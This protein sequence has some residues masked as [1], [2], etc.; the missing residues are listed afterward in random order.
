PQMT[1][2][3]IKARLKQTGDIIPQMLTGYYVDKLGSGRLNVYRA[4]MNIANVDLSITSNIIVE[5]H[6]GDGDGIPNIGETISIKVEVQ[7]GFGAA[8]AVGVVA[9]ILPQI[10]GVTVSQNTLNYGTIESGNS[11][12]PINAALVIVD[13]SV[14]TL[15]I[16]FTI[17]ITANQ[18]TDFAFAKTFPF[19]INLSMSKPNWPLELNGKAVTAPKVAD[20]DGTG[21]RFVTV[22]DGI[23]HVVDALKNYNEGFPL[24][25]ELQTQ[26]NIAIGHLNGAANTQQIVVITNSG[27]VMMI[28]HL[29]QIV[30]SRNIGFVVRTSPM[31][32][33]LVGNGQN[34]IIFGTQNQRVFILNGHDLSDWGPSP[35][36]I[37]GGIVSQMALGDLNNNG[38]KNI[39]FNTANPST[40]IHALDPSTGENLPGFPI[41]HL[42][43][44]GPSLADL[45]GDGYLEIVIS[46]NNSVNCPVRIYKFDGS[47]VG[48]TTVPSRLNTEIALV[49][50]FENGSVKLVFG[51]VS[52]NLYVLNSDLSNVNGFPKAL[53][54]P[55]TVS[56]VFATLGSESTKSS[57]LADNA[58]SL[59]IIKAS[60][61]YASGY[62]F[63]LECGTLNDAAWIG[64]LNNDNASVFLVSAAA[65]QCIDTKI[66]IRGSFWSSYRANIGN[67]ACFSDIRTPEVDD[68]EPLLTN[69]LLQNYPNPFNPITTI[70]FSI[71]RDG[72]VQIFVYNIKGQLVNT[73]LNEPKKAGQH[74]VRW[75]GIDHQNKAVASG[76]YFYKIQTENF[77]DVK[78]MILVK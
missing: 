1:P 34:Q 26:T 78:K 6:D 71:K 69:S 61:Q 39:V 59:H 44:I 62:P 2:L 65:V 5:E 30:A 28:N 75:N 14:N 15:T 77:T 54:S 25:L 11:V 8:D 57:V 38:V 40:A 52:G 18:G 60:G 33:D 37:N 35:I 10:N 64:A 55:F 63:N 31:I 53:G 16:P 51:D 7:N 17:Q 58:G 73:L 21:N 68:I 32:A 45:N 19:T 36:T 29:G 13:S 76:L 23:V 66:P 27:V 24:D 22:Y 70:D 50:L 67:T 9:T 56:P 3:E 12:T 49:D 48:E 41:S 43:N 20:L 42:T 46:G 74:Q 47:L 72:N 4:L